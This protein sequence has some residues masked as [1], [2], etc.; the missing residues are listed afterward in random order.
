[1]ACDFTYQYSTVHPVLY[2][3]NGVNGDNTFLKIAE[4]FHN[5]R[6][7]ATRRDGRRPGLFDDKFIQDFWDKHQGKSGL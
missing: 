4:T 6:R 7:D 3:T 2:G 1:M 5:A